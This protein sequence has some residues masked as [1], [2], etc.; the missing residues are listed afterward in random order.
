MVKTKISLEVPTIKIK[1]K[2][3]LAIGFIV[4][5]ILWVR[6]Q[7]QIEPYVGSWEVNTTPVNSYEHGLGV[8]KP[9]QG[10]MWYEDYSHGL[11]FDQVYY[12]APD[13]RIAQSSWIHTDGTFV[14]YPV[15][16]LGIT[17]EHARETAWDQPVDT[18]NIP[19]VR[20][21]VL[22][23]AGDPVLAEDGVTQVYKT[24]TLYYDLHF[25][26]QTIKLATNADVRKADKDWRGEIY[27]HE[28]SATARTHQGHG[29]LG[30]NMD[31]TVRF[32]ASL[33]EWPI[34]STPRDGTEIDQKAG[35][36]V[37]KV[38]KLWA[39]NAINLALDEKAKR[40]D[41]D[42]WEDWQLGNM[43]Q[44]GLPQQGENLPMWIDS[45]RTQPFS[46]QDVHE[47]NYGLP[48]PM[49]KELFFNLH[50]EFRCGYIFGWDTTYVDEVI[51]LIPV[52]GWIIWGV[53]MEVL[54]VKGYWL[55]TDPD[56]DPVVPDWERAT[57]GEP[58][59]PPL[60]EQFTGLFDWFP[61]GGFGG[62]VTIVIL[63]IVGLVALQF[64]PLLRRK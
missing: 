11:D 60:W 7:F 37:I 13:L 50:G 10:L 15:P 21:P 30:R 16:E 14:P 54:T 24:T 64:L 19:D 23:E 42:E 17:M 4:L 55:Y 27:E 5:M 62:I 40:T 52:N 22:D 12:G 29:D 2:Q 38:K 48:R 51:A 25:F 58:D 53:M 39:G 32:K 18:L 43:V 3:A 49:P 28:T 20:V 26:Y 34:R 47:G 31:A 56:G 6:P 46:E 44:K 36:L 35:I 61:L 59:R 63:V 57:G 45:S 41:V 1:R 9:F 33:D 8:E